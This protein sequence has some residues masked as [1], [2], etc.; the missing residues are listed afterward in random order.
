MPTSEQIPSYL[1]KYCKAQEYARYTAREHSTWRYILRQATD[2]FKDHAVPVYLEGLKKTGISIEKIPKI[3]DMDKCLKEFG[4]GAVG[5][6]G[7]IPPSAFLDLQARGIMPIAMDM[8]TLE[9]VGYTPA[10]DIVH[11]AAGHLPILADPNYRNYFKQYATMAKKALQTKADILLYEAVRILSDI[12]ENPDTTESQLA[13]AQEQLMLRTQEVS[14]ISELNQVARMNWWTAEYG[15]VGDLKNPLIYGAG[16]LSSVAESR[17][18]LGAKVRKIRLSL[19]CVHQ[20]YDITEPQPQLFVAESLEQLPAVLSE[21]ESTL[22]Y[23]VGGLESLQKALRTETVTSCL[24]ESGV[25]VSGLLTQVLKFQ[26]TVSFI[27]YAGPVQLSFNENEIPGQGRARHSEGFSSPVGRWKNRPQQPPSTFD[28]STLAQLGIKKGHVATVE[29][30]SGFTVEGEVIDWIRTEGK[31]AII[32]WKNCT[33]KHGEEVFYRP[34]WGDF[35]Q[36][37]GSE[38][39]SVYA[40][41]TDREQYGDYE[42]GKV[43]TTP[44]RTTPYSALENKVSV[45]YDGLRKM[46]DEAKASVNELKRL[47]GQILSQAP[48]EWLLN[49]EILELLNSALVHAEGSHSLAEH[50]KERLQAQWDQSPPNIQELIHEGLRLAAPHNSK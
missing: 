17:H 24:F 11:E 1:K 8:R 36:I 31:L 50:L 32:H 6:S 23:R 12:K 42:L 30:T 9:H 44:G 38:I 28:E 4:W 10:P 40:G 45:F 13:A 26:N 33:V 19:E 20:P 16:L 25:S 22:S 21:L 27:K 3:Q 47:S 39:L 18:C 37:L 2:F 35:D 46:R 48:E 49:V 15:L 43:S 7:F 29:F 14:E 34:E 5:V 41:P